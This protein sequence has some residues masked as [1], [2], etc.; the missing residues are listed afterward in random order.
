MDEEKVS[1]I[2]EFSD[3]ITNELNDIIERLN[4]LSEKLD[5]RFKI[6]PKASIDFEHVAFCVIF[7]SCLAK[8]D[9]IGTKIDETIEKL[10]HRSSLIDI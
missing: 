9:H 7:T 8:L 10:M 4:T 6:D 5:F 1:L 3:E 2:Q